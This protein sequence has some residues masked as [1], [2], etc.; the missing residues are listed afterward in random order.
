[1]K[2]VLLSLFALLLLAAPGESRCGGGNGIFSRMAERRH[3][4]IEARQ[5]VRAPMVM[6]VPV[7][8]I[9]QMPQKI[10]PQLQQAPSMQFF[11]G[12]ADGQCGNARGRRR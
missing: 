1:M 8:R 2:Y 9:Q 11:G 10:V 3:A 5:M 12:C 4:R 6:I 7:E